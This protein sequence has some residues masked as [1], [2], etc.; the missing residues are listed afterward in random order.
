LCRHHAYTETDRRRLEF[1]ERTAA[2]LAG[3]EAGES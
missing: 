1:E 3:W 2:Q